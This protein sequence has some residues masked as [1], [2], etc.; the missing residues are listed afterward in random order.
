MAE[1]ILLRDTLLAKDG[2]AE[3]RGF[4]FFVPVGEAGFPVPEGPWDA[5]GFREDSHVFYVADTVFG[6]RGGDD[7]KLPEVDGAAGCL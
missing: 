4:Y 7:S 3:E 1:A 5:V 2:F 6:I